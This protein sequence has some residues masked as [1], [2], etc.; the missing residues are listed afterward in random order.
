MLV[1]YRQDGRVQSFGYYRDNAVHHAE[2]VRKHVSGRDAL[3]P[4]ALVHRLGPLALPPRYAVHRLK[5]RLR[6]GRI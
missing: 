2:V 6:E 4:Y 3:R 5:R 1:D